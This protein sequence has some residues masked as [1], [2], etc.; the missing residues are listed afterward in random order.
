MQ[1]LWAI[2]SSGNFFQPTFISKNYPK[3]TLEDRQKLI[4][5]NWRYSM[6][7]R[8]YNIFELFVY[9]RKKIVNDPSNC[10]KSV[11]SLCWRLH[12]KASVDEYVHSLENW[13]F[14][15][16]PKTQPE[17]PYVQHHWTLCITQRGKKTTRKFSGAKFLQHRS[18]GEMVVAVE[19]PAVP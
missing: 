14:V 1:I 15:A 9:T 8:I 7:F 10:M 17:I 12:W 18:I 5:V 6:K 2:C 19:Q 4:N 11:E 3:F 13:I 16:W